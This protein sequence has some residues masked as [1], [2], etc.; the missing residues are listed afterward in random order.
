M[1]TCRERV[2]DKE[3]SKCKGS[4]VGS[5]LGCSWRPGWLERSEQVE[6][7]SQGGLAGSVGPRL[8]RHHC[9]HHMDFGSSPGGK[10]ETNGVF[11]NRGM[12]RTGFNHCRGPGWK[13]G[14]QLEGTV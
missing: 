7:G 13:L 2:L 5:Y 10:Y 6:S 11:G 8:L 4:L 9:R 1:L 12:T 3:E 14:D